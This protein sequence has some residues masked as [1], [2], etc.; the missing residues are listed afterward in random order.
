MAAVYLY[1]ADLEAA[2]DKMRSTLLH[3]V[4]HHGGTRYHETITR[5]WMIQ[6]EKHLDRGMCLQAAVEHALTSLAD[7]DLVYQ[8]Y[9]RELLG[10]ATAKTEWV[11][12]DLRDL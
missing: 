12:P 11:G 10:T 3:F 7:K 4:T 9:S 6:M 1:G 2:L 5:F 8:Y